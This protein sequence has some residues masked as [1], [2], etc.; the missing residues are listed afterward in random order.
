M[1]GIFQ[2]KVE[3]AA[4]GHF[5]GQQNKWTEFCFSLLKRGKKCQNKYF[6]LWSCKRFMFCTIKNKLMIDNVFQVH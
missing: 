1:I 6:H 2:I 5:L 3:N 4:V